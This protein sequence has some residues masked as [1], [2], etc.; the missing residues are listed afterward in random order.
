MKAKYAHTNIV[1][2]DWKKLAKFYVDVFG[3]TPMPP[4][5][6]A[7]GRWV[8]EVTALEEA[9]VRG[10]H[11]RL[12]GWGED[13]PTL[14]IFQYENEVAADAKTPNLEG[15]AHIAFSVD[16]VDACVETVKQYGG[17][18]VGKIVRTHISGA[19]D[20]RLAYARDPEGNIVEIQK[21]G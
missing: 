8:D 13:G 14:E 3:C 18:L 12:P 19:G 7:C 4:E 17:G 21:W 9:H 16:D 1:A 10:I 20:I 5:R 6:D 2:R 11:L 15:F